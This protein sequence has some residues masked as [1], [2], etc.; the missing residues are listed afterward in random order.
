MEQSYE[1]LECGTKAKSL[2]PIG[3][4]AED[5]KNDFDQFDLPICFDAEEEKREL[6]RRDRMIEDKWQQ[7]EDS[8]VTYEIEPICNKSTSCAICVN[9]DMTCLNQY[10]P[11]Q[12]VRGT[13]HN[14]KIRI[15]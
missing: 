7:A 15:K 9:E 10:T 5:A 1:I 6:W 2:N 14:G 8:R 12:I 13:I 3:E 11:G 4:T